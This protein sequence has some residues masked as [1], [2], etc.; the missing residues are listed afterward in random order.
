MSQQKQSNFWNTPL[1]SSLIKGK[2]V[3]LPEMLLGYFIGPVGGLLSSGI[4]TSILNTYFTDVLK[5]DLTF[6]TTL[7]LVS[8]I[9]IV[10]ANLVVGQLIERTRVL[11]GKARPWILLSALTLSVASVLMF[12]VPFE[13]V[14][15]MVW[16]AIAY[17]LYYSVA[18]PIYNTA[19]S[20]LVAVSTRNSD[21][22]GQLASF[23]NIAG[24]AAMGA[25]SMVFPILVS[26]ALKENQ[27]LWFVAMLAVGILTALTVFLQYKFSRERV[28][29]ELMESGEEE[30]EEDKPKAASMGTQFKAVASEKWWWVVMIFYMIFQFSGAI[31]NGS[32]SYFCRWMLDNS[33]MGA[34]AW[35]TYQSILAIMG[36]IPMAV[37]ML[38]VNPLCQK[39]GKRT[40]VSVFLVL[41]VIG[42]VIAG[43]GG[44]NIVPVAVGVALKCLGSSPACYMILAMLADVID[45]IEW[46][47]GLR[48][49][50]LTMSIYSSL[51][52]AASPV[53]NAV[54]SAILN[55]VGYDQNL[56][57][58]T[59]MQSA[60]AQTG[61]SVSYIWIETVAYAVCAVLLFL[62]FHV[63]DNLKAEQAEIE[64]RNKAAK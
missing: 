46:K 41:G 48:T 7:Q 43:M 58:G 15:K 42:G 6:L 40:T 23:T 5:L 36:A 39:F 18:Y 27:A 62:F 1:T 55:A 17:N 24:L 49:D 13:G 33:A 60:L 64:K 12:I 31:K 47:T 44:S 56:V 45:H 3:K 38:F 61:I 2:D 32:M 22:R 29:E 8:T 20:T 11:A 53:M 35:G 54:F 19:N 21:Q 34:D 52:V 57:V 59:G 30:Q 28:T 50:G 37:A 26:F 9:L 14:M 51:M 25:G 16:I 4:F 63:E 10:I